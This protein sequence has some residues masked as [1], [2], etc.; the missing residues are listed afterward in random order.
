M[1]EDNGLYS[2]MLHTHEVHQNVPYNGSGL[3]ESHVPINPL[4]T[5]SKMESR[6]FPMLFITPKKNKSGWKLTSSDHRGITRANAFAKQATGNES[7]IS[8][9]ADLA[10]PSQQIVINFLG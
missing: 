10:S 4:A 7:V 3:Q 9:G 2:T 1:F 6:G 5:T 8:Q